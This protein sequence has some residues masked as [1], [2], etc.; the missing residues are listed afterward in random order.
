MVKYRRLSKEELELLEDS[1]IRFLAAQSITGEDWKSIQKNDVER[2]QELIDKFSDVV[3]EKTLHNVKILEQRTTKR[4]LFFRF[5]EEKVSLFGIE[6]ES[7][8]PFGLDEGFS[9]ADLQN[10][11]E[12]KDSNYSLLSGTKAYDEDKLQEAF[13]FLQEGAQIPSDENLFNFVLSLFDKNEGNT[14]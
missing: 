11:M 14:D 10:A 2:H 13:K 7:E 3:I 9:L 1:F 5:E 12:E 6:F 8:L 4:A